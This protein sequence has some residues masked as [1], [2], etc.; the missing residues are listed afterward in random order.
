MIKETNLTKQHILGLD[1]LR[2]FCA[3][4]VAAYH[5]LS[6]DKYIEFSAVSRYG[7]YIFFVLSGFSIHYQYKDR[8]KKTEDIKIFITNR[9][10]RLF[11]LLFLVVILVNLK[12]LII[13]A[14]FF[15]A[16][17][18]FLTATLLFG[19]GAP[20]TT[21]AVTGGWSLGIEFSFYMLYPLIL[22]YCK[23]NFS[24]LY[25]CTLFLLLKTM[26]GAY[27]FHESYITYWNVLFTTPLSFIF[28]FIAGC[29]LANIYQNIQNFTNHIIVYF[30]LIPLMFFFFI[31]ID[32]DSQTILTGH[33]GFLF[34]VLSCV[35]VF[36]YALYDPQNFITKSTAKFLGE[37]SYGTY[38]LHPL[39]WNFFKKW[40]AFIDSPVYRCISVLIS[41]VIISFFI[42]K[43]Y[44]TPFIYF[45]KRLQKEKITKI[46]DINTLRDKRTQNFISLIVSVK[47]F[48]QKILNKLSH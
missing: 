25:M 10:T 43:L 21:S 20:A 29:Y 2:G 34:T 27:V 30:S 15:Q 19:L 42:K 31:P 4:S 37:I 1:V 23:S 18:S 28:Y 9:F 14:N 45:L 7:V 33:L 26:F 22:A 13:N 36:A 11:P 16:A 5:I 12:S 47:S 6:W 3:L 39:V 41:T 38:L 32:I 35:I 46:L 44:E 40:G 17:T 8:I 48:R 24:F